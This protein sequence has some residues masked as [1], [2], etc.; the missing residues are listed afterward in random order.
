MRQKFEMIRAPV[1]RVVKGARQTAGLSDLS[2]PPSMVEA[3]LSVISPH[4][5]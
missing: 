1:E 2:G 3:G 4:E 5:H